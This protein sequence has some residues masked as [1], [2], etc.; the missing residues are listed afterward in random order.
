M[1]FLNQ[2]SNSRLCYKKKYP[3]FYVYICSSLACG[4]FCCYIWMY[5]LKKVA[6]MGC[7]NRI[8]S[9]TQK[10]HI[11]ATWGGTGHVQVIQ[12][13]PI[14]L[15]ICCDSCLP[16]PVQQLYSPSN[17][18]DT[19]CVIFLFEYICPET[20]CTM[21]TSS[22]WIAKPFLVDKYAGVGLELRP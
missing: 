3:A 17:I 1:F 18:M 9:M 22:L 7:V 15:F 21:L 4:L 2:D 6:H 12:S 5:Q 16:K 14:S 20:E 10:P 11:C 19:I 13:Y 8:R